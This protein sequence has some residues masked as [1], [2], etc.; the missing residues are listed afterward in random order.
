MPTQTTISPSDRGLPLHALAQG[1][2][3]GLVAAEALAAVAAQLKTARA[4]LMALVPAMEAPRLEKFFQRNV[5]AAGAASG[6]A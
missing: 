6:I 2:Q 1:L 4:A 5:E 3:R